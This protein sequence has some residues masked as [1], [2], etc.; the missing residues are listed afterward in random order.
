M[1]FIQRKGFT[2]G[3]K[4]KDS[5]ISFGLRANRKNRGRLLRFGTRET[6]QI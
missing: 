4:R 6:I 5:E 3:Y 2:F 1:N